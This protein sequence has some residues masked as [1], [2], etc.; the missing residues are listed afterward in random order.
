MKPSAGPKI[1]IEHFKGLSDFPLQRSREYKDYSPRS[2]GVMDLTGAN[3]LR[4]PGA[5]AADS[6]S[7]PSVWS[8]GQLR[9]RDRWHTVLGMLERDLYSAGT[10]YINTPIRF[11]SANPTRADWEVRYDY[12]EAPDTG[13]TPTGEP[14]V[15]I[16]PSVCHSWW[17]LKQGRFTQ[18][19][20]NLLICQRSRGGND[21]D[22][23]WHLT[24]VAAFDAAWASIV[25]WPAFWVWSG[26]A[27]IAPATTSRGHFRVTMYYQFVAGAWRYSCDILWHEYEHKVCS[28]DLVTP[29]NT[30]WGTPYEH[31]LFVDSHA[32]GIDLSD[33][34]GN[35]GASCGE[36]CDNLVTPELN[37]GADQSIHQPQARG[38]YQNWQPSVLDAPGTYGP[39][40]FAPTDYDN[41]E[42]KL[43]F[44]ADG[45]I[46]ET[47]ESHMGGG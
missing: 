43:I 9:F 12:G 39:T 35:A 11:S 27:K 19:S 40:D 24:A 28:A 42:I 21:S 17:S 14:I 1:I 29:P 37:I 36:T 44:W 47:H 5:I 23:A 10:P 4:V 31:V 33:Y 13:S 26:W 25:A 18:E 16:P 7:C 8:L 34:I 20:T 15:E 38:Y 2:L 6:V 46:F 3:L 45:G 41:D 32:Y 22:A 30:P